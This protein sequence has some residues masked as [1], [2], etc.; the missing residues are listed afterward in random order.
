MANNARGAI[1][2]KK[3]KNCQYN[4]S[5]KK[6]RKLRVYMIEKNK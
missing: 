2:K 4:G 5:E 6:E 1:I 3:T